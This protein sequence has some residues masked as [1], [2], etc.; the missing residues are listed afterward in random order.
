METGDTLRT[1][2]SALKKW[3]KRTPVNALGLKRQI[4]ANV[5]E[6]ESYVV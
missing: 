2:L 5:I 4:A 3:T 1:L 6:S